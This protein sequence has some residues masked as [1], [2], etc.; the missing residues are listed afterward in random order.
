MSYAIL[1]CAVA[2]LA[3]GA[4]GIIVA[5][6]PGMSCRALAA[7]QGF[8]AGVMIGISLFNMLPNSFADLLQRMPVVQAAASLCGM[9]VCGWAISVFIARVAVPDGEIGTENTMKSVC[10]IT[11]MIIVLHNLPEGMLTAFSGYSDRK[12][13]ADMAFAVALH[14]IPEGVAVA[15]SVLCLESSRFKAVMH[16]FVAGLAELA[17]GVAALLLL[18]RFITPQLLYAV[19]AVISGIMVQVSLC[20]LIPNGAKLHSVRAVI[21]GIIAGV[22]TIS[23]GILMI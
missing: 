21:C 15:S 19:L 20:Q 13:G 1:L 9:F 10:I 22:A 8:A 12:L 23:L 11:T 6:W 2:S 14:N 3:T 7:F 18:H 16:S 5:L 17:G 4:G